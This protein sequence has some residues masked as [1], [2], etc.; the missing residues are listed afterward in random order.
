M[1]YFLYTILLSILL[2]LTMPFLVWKYIS[3]TK[4]KG[5]IN[6]RFGFGFPQFFK[7]NKSPIIWLHAVSVG[8]TMAAKGW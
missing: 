7:E 1:H 8:E 4:Y 3:T 6:Q 2:L 5:T